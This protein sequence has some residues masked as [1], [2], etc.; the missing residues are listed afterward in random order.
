MTTPFCAA[1]MSRM[2]VHTITTKPWSLR[3]CID[4]YRA[5]NVPG[6][7]VWRQALAPQGPQESAKMLADSGLKVVALVRGGFFTGQDA[8]T[9][10]AALDDNRRALDEASTIGAPLVVLVCGAT[11]GLPL[12]DARKQIAGAIAALAPDAQARQ[13]RLAIEPLHPM[14]AADRSAVVTMTQAREICQGFAA[15]LPG[16]V[17][18]RRLVGIAVDVYHVWWDQHLEREIAAAGTLGLLHAFHVCDWR[19]QTRDLLNDRGLMGEG[20]INIRQI[21]GWMERAGFQGWVEVEVFSTERWAGDQQAW[22][23]HIL[24][25]YQEH[26]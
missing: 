3:E 5:R 22:L 2:A 26:V 10:Q 6:I 14:Y 13:V 15:E 16:P 17:C 8:A 12:A 23:D 18:G 11:P 7:T 24:N 21:R 19:V 25:A 20:C 1:P 9:R 4:Q